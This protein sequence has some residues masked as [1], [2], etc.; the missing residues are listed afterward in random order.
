MLSVLRACE[1]RRNS[2]ETVMISGPL[3]VLKQCLGDFRKKGLVGR[4]Q[5]LNRSGWRDGW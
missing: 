5:S 1:S 3:D 4:L 2:I